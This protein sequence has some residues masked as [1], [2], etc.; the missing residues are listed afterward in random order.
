MSSHEAPLK[1]T[2]FLESFIPKCLSKDGTEEIQKILMNF[3]KIFIHIQT[4]DQLR[5]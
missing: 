2:F 5:E 3:R 4:Q 1:S